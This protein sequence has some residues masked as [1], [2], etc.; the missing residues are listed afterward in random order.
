[1]PYERS[2]VTMARNSE[3]L[4]SKTFA[5][6]WVLNI[7]FRVRIHL[8]RMAW[9]KGKIGPCARWLERCSTSIGLREGFGLRWSVPRATCRTGSTLGFTR[10]EHA[11]S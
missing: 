10:R 7:S 3:I 4:T 8:P 2:V 1:M 9:W 6:T 11:T 5:M